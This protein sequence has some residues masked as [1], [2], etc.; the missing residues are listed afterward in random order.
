M[1]LSGLVQDMQREVGRLSEI[2]DHYLFLAHTR[3]PKRC[4]LQLDRFMAEIVTDLRRK[5]VGHPVEFRYIASTSS[6]MIRLDPAKIRRLFYDLLD[7]AL[8]AMPDGGTITLHTIDRDNEMEVRFSD[9][10]IGIATDRLQRVFD[11]FETSKSTGSGL[12][13]YIV[14]EIV[15][16]HAGRVEIESQPDQGTTV[17]VRMPLVGPGEDEKGRPSAEAPFGQVEHA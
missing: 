1:R 15:L 7:N 5:I 6:R 10:G 11:P 13:L 2:V 12:G 3:S 14:R 16:A 9:T 8:D 17:I 4:L